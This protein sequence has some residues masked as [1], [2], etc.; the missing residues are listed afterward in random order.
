M[1]TNQSLFFP[2]S[3]NHLINS[4]FDKD[5]LF[6]PLENLLNSAFTNQF[7]ELVDEL[8]ID[9][10]K[11]SYPKVNVKETSN[12]FQITAEIPGIE[13]ENV[14]VEY[15]EKNGILK[16]FGDKKTKITDESDEK[17]DKVKW[18]RKEIKQSSFTRSFFIKPDIIDNKNIS[19]TYKNDYL[20]IIIPKKTNNDKKSSKQNIEIK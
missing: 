8:N 11:A 2:R 4:F 7:P 13:K 5:E 6:S 9:F 19:A 17:D 16:I 12:N 3:G 10:D 14:K 18:I 20:Q 15:D 1:S